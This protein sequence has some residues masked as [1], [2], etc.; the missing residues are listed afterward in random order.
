MGHATDGKRE[1]A[2]KEVAR[3]SSKDRNAERQIADLDRTSNILLEL[4]ENNR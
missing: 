2:V 1:M 4:I 3:P